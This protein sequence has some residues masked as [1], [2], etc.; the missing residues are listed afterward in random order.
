MSEHE[1]DLHFDNWQVVDST[2]VTLESPIAAIGSGHLDLY[3]EDPENA[4]C[5]LGIAIKMKLPDAITT[6]FRACEEHGEK[7]HVRVSDQRKNYDF[8]LT[9]ND[10]G[11]RYPWRLKKE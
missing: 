1:T 10:D 2:H 3:L 9:Y 7:L 8:I 5:G 6:T 4:F 11:G